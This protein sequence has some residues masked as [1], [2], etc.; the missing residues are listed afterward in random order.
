MEG[1]KKDCGWVVVVCSWHQLF[2]NIKDHYI[3]ENDIPPSTPIYNNNIPSAPI[4]NNA[5]P[6]SA[7]IYDNAISTVAPS[8]SNLRQRYPKSSNLWQQYPSKF[9]NL[10][11]W[12]HKCSKL[13]QWYPNC[14]SMKTIVMNCHLQL[15]MGQILLNC[16]TLNGQTL[17]LFKLYYDSFC[18]D[19]YIT[20]HIIHMTKVQISLHHTYSLNWSLKKGIYSHISI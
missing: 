10:W 4:Y 11:K 2:H 7:L 9:S 17:L 14:H 20:P 16:P 6:Q 15:G 18:A 5:I 1:E 13:W 3:Y 19:I 8:C 12:Y